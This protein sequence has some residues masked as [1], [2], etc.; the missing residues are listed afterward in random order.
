M[1]P[2]FLKVPVLTVEWQLGNDHLD[3]Y[4][5][6]GTRIKDTSQL[7]SRDND[8]YNCIVS[9]DLRVE[10][11]TFGSRVRIASDKSRNYLCFNR[12]GRLT[13][14]VSTNLRLALTITLQLQ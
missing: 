14:R 3:L 13:V 1:M 5:N 12:R 7:S 10:T 4:V 8:F 11:D 2:D 9:A 6:K